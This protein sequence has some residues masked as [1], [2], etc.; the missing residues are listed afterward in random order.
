LK[1]REQAVEKLSHVGETAAA[2]AAKTTTAAD[3]KMCIKQKK[4]RI[5]LLKS[6]NEAPSRECRLRGENAGCEERMQAARRE[7]W[8]RGENAGI[9]LL[10]K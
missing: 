2:A 3:K 8:L 7:R 1:G 10:I 5:E 6:D 9:Q 4:Y